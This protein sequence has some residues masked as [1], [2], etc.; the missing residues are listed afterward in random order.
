MGT[1]IVNLRIR[2]GAYC[3]HPYSKMYIQI[4]HMYLS[5]GEDTYAGQAI[6]NAFFEG[7][8]STM[9]IHRVSTFHLSQGDCKLLNIIHATDLKRKVGFWRTVYTLPRKEIIKR[10]RQ[11]LPLELLTKKME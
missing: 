8:E 11:R 10:L 4:S 3:G 1:K 7:R 5:V 6:F 9:D 2:H